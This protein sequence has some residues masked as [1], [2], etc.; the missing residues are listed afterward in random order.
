MLFAHGVFLKCQIAHPVLATFVSMEMGQPLCSGCQ[1]T[2]EQIR[3]QKLR[4]C[5]CFD[6]ENEN[7]N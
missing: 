5:R 1:L 3:E 7:P 2:G 4:S 6:S